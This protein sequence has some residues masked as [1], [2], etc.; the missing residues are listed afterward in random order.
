MLKSISASCFLA[1]TLAALPTVSLAR[2]VS[3]VHANEQAAEALKDLSLKAADAADQAAALD[4]NTRSTGLG[5]ESYVPYLQSLKDDVND[6]GRIVSYLSD[7]RSS[8]T[9]ADRAALDRAG[10]TLKELADNTTAIVEYTNRDHQNYWTATYHRYV[11]NLM[12]ESGELSGS[13]S[14]TLEL[15]RIRVR[16]KQLEKTMEAGQ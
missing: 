6:M 1:A 11:T 5:W 16:E 10:S 8:L 4:A 14:R 15:D 12:N 3:P 7:M 2:S 13:L 9:P